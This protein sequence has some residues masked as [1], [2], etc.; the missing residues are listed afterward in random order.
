[1]YSHA[2]FAY[3]CPF[4]LFASGDFSS[5]VLL[6]TRNDLVYED[7]QIMSFVSSHQWPANAGHVL[8]IPREHYE[9]IYD[10]PLELGGRIH[11]FARKVALCMKKVYRC[12]GIST[13]Q[14][15]EPS[16]DQDVWHYH[17][18]VFPRYRGDDLYSS[19]YQLMPES[20]RGIYASAL[21]AGLC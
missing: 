20:E 16:G 13:R 19:S 17:M 6:S 4:C 1:M 11:E 8:I 12:D 18:H 7:E 21:R 5:E 15:N 9:N 14:H 10:L 3:I 2:P